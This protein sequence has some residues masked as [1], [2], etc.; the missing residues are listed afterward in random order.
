MARVLGR[1]QQSTLSIDVAIHVD[2]VNKLLGLVGM[3]KLK[4]TVPCF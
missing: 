3:F 4:S 2:Q 1:F